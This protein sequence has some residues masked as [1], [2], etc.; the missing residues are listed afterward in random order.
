MADYQ[1]QSSPITQLLVSLFNM[2]KIGHSKQKHHAPF[3]LALA[4]DLVVD[5]DALMYRHSVLWNKCVFSQWDEWPS[6]T[7]PS[8]AQFYIVLYY[9]A[10]GII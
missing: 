5:Q 8:S 10:L 4:P 6:L 2:A 7:V 9:P 1:L 3:L